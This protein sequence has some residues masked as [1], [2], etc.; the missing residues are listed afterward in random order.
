MKAYLL[1]VSLFPNKLHF[2]CSQQDI[3]LIAH[4]SINYKLFPD[5]HLQH[6]EAHTSCRLDQ[7]AV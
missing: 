2:R 3:H 6:G 4:T 5:E 7:D 1:F